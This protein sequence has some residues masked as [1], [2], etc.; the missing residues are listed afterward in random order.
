M[1]KNLLI[2]ILSILS[3]SCYSQINFEN[4]YFIKNTGETIHCLIKNIDWKNNP[5]Q[6]I[7]KLSKNSELKT[8]NVDSI[9]EFGFLDIVKYKSFLVNI[10]RSS[11]DLYDMSKNKDPEFKEEHLFLNTL[12]EGKAT[13]YS[14]ND[15][16]LVRY[17]YSTDNSYP[18]QLIYKNYKTSRGEIQDY[19]VV[20]VNNKFREQLWND[21]KCQTF[22]MSYLEQ[23]DYNKQ[24]LVKFFEKYNDCENSEFKNYDK[25]Q[26]KESFHL[27]VRPGIN[28]SSLSTS[29]FI[30]GFKNTTEIFKNQSTFRLGF[31]AE[32]ILPF[33]KNKWSIFIDPNY[34]YYKSNS[35]NLSI[36]YNSIE[37][38]IG[39]RHY[40]FLNEY[41]KFFIS[42]A[43]ISDFHINSKLSNSWTINSNNNYAVGLG[44]HYKDKYSI[45]MRYMTNRD[46]LSDYVYF[47]SDYKNI[48]IIFGF[49]VF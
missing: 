39:I 5:T 46:L 44:Y 37:L 22:T 27:T 25:T 26:G 30:W 34:Q 15:K 40:F 17:F 12:V 29:D 16:N 20:S 4:G 36:E 42:V 35:Q 28:N 21:L 8:E 33:N 43:Y 19:S 3:F 32:Y 14:Y 47:G 18:K 38:P 9:K 6:F 41:S 23:I 31:L 24:D 7:Y 1:K 48:S 2:V 10:D 45:E 11:N 49:N 13:L